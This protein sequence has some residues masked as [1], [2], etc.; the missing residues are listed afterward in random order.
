[1]DLITLHS[2]PVSS[3]PPPP[4]PP[5]ALCPFKFC[6]GFP[7]DRCPFSSFQSYTHQQ[8]HKSNNQH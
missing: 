1:L 6:L 5:L 4:P 3:P 2:L 8:L 7:Y